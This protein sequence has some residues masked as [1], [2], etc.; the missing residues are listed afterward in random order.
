MRHRSSAGDWSGPSGRQCQRVSIPVSHSAPRSRGPGASSA[1]FALRP[2]L[3]GQAPSRSGATSFEGTSGAKLAKLCGLDVV[4]FRE[5][6][7]RVNLL[8]AFPGAYSRGDAF[9][10]RLARASARQV[11]SRL[12]GRPFVVFVGVGVSRAFEIEPRPL[13]EFRDERSIACPFVVCPHPSGLNTWWNDVVNR[14]Q[15]SR[16]WRSLALE[17]G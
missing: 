6:F 2:L 10:L 1:L 3:V 7:D 14:E 12:Q 13:L 4:A 8:E 9:P 16:F 15:A 11:R 17:P 5:R